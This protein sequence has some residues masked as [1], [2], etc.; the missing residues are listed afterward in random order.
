MS[1]LK[2]MKLSPEHVA[3]VAELHVSGIST[4]FISS[5]GEGT[6][7]GKLCGL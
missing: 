5:P 1:G 2:I 3:Q 7:R 4:G 6:L